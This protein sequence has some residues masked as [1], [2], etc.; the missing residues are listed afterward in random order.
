MN[1]GETEKIILHREW[2]ENIL[3][4]M[5]LT[6]DSWVNIIFYYY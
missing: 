3:K 4:A 6:G 2:L 5:W 1:I